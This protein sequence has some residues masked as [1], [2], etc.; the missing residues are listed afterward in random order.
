M[1]G[2]KPQAWWDT[3]RRARL[4]RV[5]A[6]YLGTSFVVIQLVDIF[7]DQLGL[8]DWFFPGAAALLLIGLP[9]V[10]ATALVQSAPRPE[11][12]TSSADAAAP[13]SDSPSETVAAA[14]AAV[15]KHWLTWN[16]AILGGVLA[17]ALLGVAVTAY[18][19]MRV[20]GIGPVGSL[21]AAGA[22]ER[23][24]RIILAEFENLTDDS[25]LAAVVTE[26]FRIDISQSPTITIAEPAFVT[27][28][29]TRMGKD[30]GTNLDEVMAREVAVRAGLKAVIAGEVASLGER[31]I[32]S[33]RLV[34]A[35]SGEE[36]A[37][38][39][40]AADGVEELIEAIEQLSRKM[41]E[42][43]GES[44]KTIRAN[45]PLADV[46]TSSLE[47]L[48]KYSQALRAVDANEI[49]RARELLE[50]AVALD[51]AFA[52]AW[53]KLGVTA[54]MS[55]ASQREALTKAYEHRDRLTDRERYMT[56]GTYYELVTSEHQKAIAA[57]ETLLQSYP[58]EIWAL[59][60][61][62]LIY[63]GEREYAR[64][65]ELYTRI[66]EVDSTDATY[67]VRA[68]H[69]RVAQGK[70]EQAEAS[71]A[72]VRERFP[73]EPMARL[74]W[75]EYLV[76]TRGDHEGAE[77][78][79]RSIRQMQLPPFTRMLAEFYLASVNAVRG[80][81]AEAERIL[82]AGSSMSERFGQALLAFYFAAFAA[83][84][85]VALRSDT[86]AGALAFEEA[87]AGFP[88][89]DT[90]LLDRPYVDIASW[91]AALGQVE[92]ARS[93]LAE[94]EAQVP[95]D[96]RRAWESQWRMALGD[97]ALAERRYDDAIAEYR[98]ADEA[99]RSCPVCALPSLARAFDRAQRADSAI[100][101]YER[102]VTSPWFGQER[103]VI[104]WELPNSYERLGSLYEQN[105]DAERAIYYYGRLVD[106][107]EDADPEL[108]PRVDAARRAIDALST[109][110]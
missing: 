33:A 62:A 32:V 56:L 47:A 73:D 23:G 58:N 4:F 12:A 37:S 53:R 84:I 65:E 96:E 78:E 68:I 7:T 22:L 87:L 26:S 24:Q 109:D 6:V 104:D 102:Y 72:A 10:V 18:T 82:T 105:G 1:A 52:M 81:L 99:N 77:A 67:W 98:R 2:S 36:L 88:L 21:V 16:R 42:R 51:T 61:L 45:E 66:L 29:L 50:E 41:R 79:Q 93:V 11:P 75:V 48:R 54:L 95:V 55:P 108:H 110:R 60:N 13:V 3:I 46:T 40:E 70:G 38:F 15:A 85:D 89:E 63:M 94:Y 100:A 83:N 17:F 27:R 34:S 86:A 90:P 103:M 64:A 25:V 8:P 74:A 97:I 20:L 71:F 35:E 107:W 9:I 106:L 80:N 43:I 69:M 14:E 92:R 57:Y 59:N 5:L 31:Y 44:L 91:Y 28:M 30:A 39:Q 101:A 49:I 76:S 19:A